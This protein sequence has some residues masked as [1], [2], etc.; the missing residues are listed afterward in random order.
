MAPAGWFGKLPTLGDF[1]S[2]RLPQE[3]I[4]PWDSWLQQVV[5]GSQAILSERW[6]GTYLTS[7]I[8]RFVLAE[9][10]LDSH[11]WAGI[12]VPSVDR[13]GRY[14]P[15]CIAA[16]L[17]PDGV[18]SGW[19]EALEDCARLALGSVEVGTFDAAL[20]AIS[21]AETSSA[22]SAEQT[23]LIN[24]PEPFPTDTIQSILAGACPKHSAWC[25]GI[26]PNRENSFLL[27]GMPD[28]ATYV[29]MLQRA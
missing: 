20:M 17:T 18:P 13:V 11:A 2:R 1:A 26:K 16:K 19:F 15:L 8:W 29:A 21:A 3:F 23:L 28:T 7:H 4:K 24:T 5:A 10:C 25:V 22:L 14:F 9:D 6:L 27:P 12:L